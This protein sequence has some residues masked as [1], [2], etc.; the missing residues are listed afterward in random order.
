MDSDVESGADVSPPFVLSSNCYQV[1][2]NYYVYLYFNEPVDPS[3]LSISNFLI[4][5]AQITN[6]AADFFD[7][8]KVTLT[9]DNVVSNSLGLIIFQ[10]GDLNQNIGSNITYALN[11]DF[12]FT[13]LNEE[14]IN[15]KLFPNPNK[16][17]FSIQI[18]NDDNIAS[19]YDLKGQIILTHV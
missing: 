10:M 19:I 4:T 8:T 13:S 7:P 14:N 18:D 3:F 11:C 6:V 16:G 1:G 9:L 5:N 2:N 12:N 15:V 17:E